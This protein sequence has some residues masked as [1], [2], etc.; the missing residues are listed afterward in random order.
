MFSI[1][2]LFIDLR[3]KLSHISTGLNLSVEPGGSPQVGQFS[4]QINK[5]LSNIFGKE[6]YLSVKNFIFE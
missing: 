2:P 3:L 6:L 4:I 1:N 5:I